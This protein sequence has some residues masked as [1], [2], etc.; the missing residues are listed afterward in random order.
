MTGGAKCPPCDKPKKKRAAPAHAKLQTEVI[1]MIAAKEG[2]NYR[3]AIKRLKPN[4]SKAIGESWDKV[5]ESGKM[6]WM[7]AL[8]KTKVMLK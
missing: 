6:T 7:E 1:K 5:K 8:Q 3:D 2:V 4:V